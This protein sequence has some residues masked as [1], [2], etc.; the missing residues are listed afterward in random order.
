LCTLSELDYETLALEL[1]QNPEQLKTINQKL[2]INRSTMP[3]FNTKLFTKHLEN[4]YQ[5]AYQRYFDGAQPAP[6]VVPD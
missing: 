3:L 2:S 5:Q 1:A 6:I 4:G